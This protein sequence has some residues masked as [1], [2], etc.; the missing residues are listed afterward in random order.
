MTLPPASSD[1]T[2]NIYLSLAQYPILK[3][4]IRV[5]MRRELFRRGIISPQAFEAEAQ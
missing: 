5:R 1:R 4:Q 2:L 3:S